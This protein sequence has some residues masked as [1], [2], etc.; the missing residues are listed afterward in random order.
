[1]LLRR[2]L[3]AAAL[4][5]TASPA[6]AVDTGQSSAPAEDGAPLHGVALAQ[7]DTIV[8]TGERKGV[9][10][11]ATTATATRTD[12]TLND[13]PQAINVVTSEQ[14]EDQ[15]MRSMAD[16]LRFVPGVALSAGEGHRD[17]VVIRGNVSTADF[18][19]DGMRD[20]VQF[21]RGLYN[22]DRVEIL[23]GPNAMIFGRGGGGG[24]INRVLKR[25]RF[26]SFARGAVSIDGEGASFVQT[27]VNAPLLPGVAGRLNAVYEEFD[28]FRDE[29]GGHRVGFTPT[30]A[31]TPGPSTR[32]DLAFE[33]ARD[34]RAVDRGV[35]SA[36]PATIEDP[37]GA[38]RGFDETF[39][40]VEDV[41]RARFDA[42]VATAR[43]EH[44]FSP[45]LKLVSKGLYGDYDKLYQNAFPTT[46]VTA[47]GLV[48]I[49]AYRDPTRRRNLLL[50]NDLVAELTTGP[51]EH[52]LLVGMDFGDQDTRNR[53]I[54][55]FF[56]TAGGGKRVF[57]PLADPLV[58]PPI[59]FRDG[60]GN[61]SIRSRADAIGLYA[62]DQLTI[63]QHLEIVAGLRRDRFRLV[64]DDLLG[65]ETF[66]RTDS[67][68][69]PRVGAVVKPTE[70][71]SLYASWS[72]SFLPQSGEQ[73]NA[74]DLTLEALEPERFTNREVGLK[75]QPTPQFDVTLAAYQLDRTNTRERAPSGSQT[76]LTGKQ[77]SEGIELTL[78]GR[79]MDRLALAGG[80]AF[81]D[82]EIHDSIDPG[83]TGREVPLVPELQASLW[84]RYDITDRIGAGLGVH[85]QSETFASIS[86]AVVV[87]A[88]T[89]M[90]AAGYF[91]LGRGM[92][93]QLNIENL[94]DEDY[95]ALAYNDNNLTPANPRTFRATLRFDM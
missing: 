20:D 95:I 80:L 57:V 59:S 78:Q 30:L 32:V 33:Y 10:S 71:L 42:N 54:N 90:D 70:A 22:L 18:Y 7:A 29:F 72:R 76:L 91:G 92:E 46:A 8:V 16:V 11:V 39:F 50:Q 67:L 87:P 79:P 66:K 75:W 27:D 44:N 40:G 63:G 94:L 36:R 56:D 47:E 88:F 73:F 93:L 24:I 60:S 31:W 2:L 58:I 4:L 85:H 64:V 51:L 38:V 55:G 53:R 5:G 26:E 74:L 12:T 69:S 28:N 14:I 6:V 82:A 15:A 62:Q 17:Q 48:G 68:W 37:A 35:P 84:G 65:G 61:R 89:R 43:L 45:A 81:Q 83:L 13:I 21:Y 34:R 25:P 9:Y 49:E 3:V 19:L 77:R 1:M 41:N 86:N 23:K 52:V